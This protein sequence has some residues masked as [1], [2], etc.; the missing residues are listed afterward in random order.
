MVLARN[1]NVFQ[2]ILPDGK[3]IIIRAMVKRSCGAVEYLPR[4]YDIQIDYYPN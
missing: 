1:S 2:T 3:R 4:K